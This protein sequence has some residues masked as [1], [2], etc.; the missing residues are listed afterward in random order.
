VLFPR[1]VPSRSRT[2]SRDKSHRFI[3]ERGEPPRPS[4]SVATIYRAFLPRPRR[5]VHGAVHP[6]GHGHAE[7]EEDGQDHRRLAEYQTRERQASALFPGPLAVGAVTRALRAASPGDMIGVRGPFGTDWGL[8]IADGRD[9]LIVASGIG[10]ALLR[11]GGQPE[12]GRPDRSAP[13]A[14][15]DRSRGGSRVR[16]LQR[17]VTRPGGHRLNPPSGSH[18]SQVYEVAG[19]SSTIPPPTSTR[20]AGPRATIAPRVPVLTRRTGIGSLVRAQPCRA[21]VSCA[22]EANS[23]W[24]QAGQSGLRSRAAHQRRGP[25]L[26]ARSSDVGLAGAPGPTD[27]PRPAAE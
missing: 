27:V 17:C 12:P 8:S 5:S 7:D 1:G 16:H 15:H 4:T 9:V 3:D 22:Y 26:L 14:G 10:L 6:G 21:C 2:S 20:C 19:T 23:E 25:H 13:P 24:R 11:P 18:E